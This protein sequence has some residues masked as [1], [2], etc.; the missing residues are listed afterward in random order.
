[1]R[2]IAIHPDHATVEVDVRHSDRFLQGLK[3][4]R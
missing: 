3:G 4:A 1:M 2:S